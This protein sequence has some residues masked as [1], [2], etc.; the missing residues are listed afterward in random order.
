MA[1]FSELIATNSVL[2]VQEQ[3][4]L[5]ALVAEWRLLADLSFADL[6]LWLP[7][8]KDEKSWPQG[9]VAIAQIRPTTAATVFSDDLIGTKIS[10]G[11][12]PLI[13]Q[14]LSDNEVI[15]DTSD[16]GNSFISK[17]AWQLC[18]NECLDAIEER[19]NR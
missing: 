3:E 11:Q 6:V 17:S 14:A 10:W 12:R 7:I 2:S 4:H 16:W 13:D 19:H 15:K 5:A 8:R 9:Y 18:A 1:T